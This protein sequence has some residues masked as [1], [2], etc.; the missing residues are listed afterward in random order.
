ME[1]G[2]DILIADAGGTS[3]RWCLLSTDG[4]LKR[5][6]FAAPINVCVQNDREL[7][8]ALTP[9]DILLE[10]S[11]IVYFYGAGCAGE[12]E[13]ERVSNQFREL[14]FNGELHVNSD[15]LAA[16]R[17]LLGYNPGIACILG[18]GSNS[19]LYTGKEI[20]ANIRPLGYIIGDEGSGASIGKRF[21]KRLLRD[22]L[23]LAVYEEFMSVNQLSVSAIYEKVYREPRANKFLASLTHFV[24]AHINVPEVYTVV[25]EEF[26]EFFKGIVCKYSNAAH[27]PVSFVGSVAYYFSQILRTTA[28]RYGLTINKIEKNPMKGLLKYHN[29]LYSPLNRFN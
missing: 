6:M 14:G 12:Q 5:D 4:Y 27:L 18:T 21:L 17:S 2:N 13:C 20:A 22:E 28:S 15:I 19:C 3:T 8:A 25:E 7:R 16:A 26:D 11:K 24:Q 9:A 29:K 10:S 23:P 1:L